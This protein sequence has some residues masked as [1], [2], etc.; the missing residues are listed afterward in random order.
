MTYNDLLLQQEWFEKCTDILKRDQ[1]RCQKCGCLGYHNNSYFECETDDE[2][3]SCLKGISFNDETPSSFI[4]NIRACST[5]KEFNIFQESKEAER[6]RKEENRIDPYSRLIV[7]E[8]LLYD[9]QIS[10]KSSF[11]SLLLLTESKKMIQDT[12]CKGNYLRKGDRIVQISPE[13]NLQYEKGSYYKFGK[14]YFD[15]YIVRIERR[16]PTG[17][18]C[19]FAYNGGSIWDYLYGSIIMSICY[20][21]CGITLYFLDQSKDENRNPKGLN[22][23]HKY[24]IEGKKPWE[25]DNDALITLCQDCHKLE[26][27]TKQTPVYR[28]LH[29]KNIMGYAQICDRCDG[30][31][32]LPQYSHVEGG[33][34]F[35][36]QG[37][38]VCLM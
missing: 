36:C 8:K 23:H 25:Y 12:E 26:H 19:G 3:D 37:E 20:K 33:I 4:N 31:G 16:W 18:T 22:V 1:Y 34:C 5:L 28:S 27:Q 38:G 17:P 9:L 30:S 7:G 14:Q 6:K 24:Y 32:Y 13:T 15:R 29:E 35:K 10:N 21:D 2:I 11:D